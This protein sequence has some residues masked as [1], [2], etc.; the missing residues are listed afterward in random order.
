MQQVS[1]KIWIKS[2]LLALTL[3]AVLGLIA[4]AEVEGSLPKTSAS[5]PS[6]PAGK[7]AFSAT[8]GDLLNQSATPP[9][10]SVVP[11][12][13]VSEPNFPSSTNSVKSP[14]YGK[15]FEDSLEQEAKATAGQGSATSPAT[16]TTAAS[17]TAAASTTMAPFTRGAGAF[18]PLSGMQLPRPINIP[19]NSSPSL[20]Q[21][22]AMIPNFSVVSP[23]LM[24]GSQ[25]PSSAYPLLKEAGVKTIV[26]L[27]NEDILVAREAGEA[28]RAGLN[29]VNIP[30]ALFVSPTKQQFLQFLS[31]VNNAGPVFVHCQKGEDR[32][33]TMVAVYRIT[34]ENWHPNRAYQEMTAMGFKTYLGSLSGAVYDYSAS[35]GRP[36]RRPMP[37]M[38]GFTSILKH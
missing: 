31:T 21:A 38:S 11:T 18:A 32:T 3:T 23:S 28:K 24:R 4:T 14:Q 19:A 27:R 6:E 35:L 16:T 8:F 7:S 33:G 13:K 15:P 9:A 10:N 34:N 17:T 20:K 30:M 1:R 37:D 25:P 29:Y 12:E 5:Q 22:A 2:W 36:G 26:N